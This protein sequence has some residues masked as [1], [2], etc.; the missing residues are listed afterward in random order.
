MAR[1]L[2]PQLP[3][4]SVMWKLRGVLATESNWRLAHRARELWQA[5]EIEAR[6]GLARELATELPR[7]LQ[8]DR[9]AG[10]LM[11]HESAIPKTDDVCAIGRTILEDASLDVGVAN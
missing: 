9:D 3:R 11:L 4:Q 2:S 7:E 8:I 5:A 10:H 6:R 1:D